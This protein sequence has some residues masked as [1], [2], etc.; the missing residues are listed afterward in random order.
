MSGCSLVAA[1]LP[2]L[3]GSATPTFSYDQA[4]HSFGLGDNF[5]IQMTYMPTFTPIISNPL[6]F[7]TRTCSYQTQGVPATY[8]GIFC[9][10]A[11][12]FDWVNM[13]RYTIDNY[14]FLNPF[15][16]TPRAFTAAFGDQPSPSTVATS[17]VQTT[18]TAT[19]TAF[20]PVRP[21]ATTTVSSASATST[22]TNIA[23]VTFS[24]TSAITQTFTLNF[25]TLLHPVTKLI[26]F[27]F[28]HSIA[29][30]ICFTYSYPIAELVL[31]RVFYSVAKLICRTSPEFIFYTLPHPSAQLSFCGHHHSGKHHYDYSIELLFHRVALARFFQLINFTVSYSI[32]LFSLRRYH[33]CPSPSPS[34]PGLSCPASDGATFTTPQGDFVVECFIDRTNFDI[35]VAPGNPAD[36]EQCIQ[37]CGSTS[38][39][40]AVS[41]LPN[42]PCYL[43]SGLGA[44]RSN[45]GV[46]GA[47]I[48]S[49][50]VS[51]SS[52]MVTSSAGASSQS[53]ATTT[54]V[55]TKVVTA[56][57]SSS[58]AASSGASVSCPGSNGS[59]VTAS[60]MQYL[61][62]CGADYMGGDIAGPMSPTYP[63]SYEGCLAD[64][65]TTS[66]CVA[67][68]Y[69][70]NGPC[71]LKSAANSAGSN[72][73][74]IGGRL[75]RIV[76]SSAAPASSTAPASS[77]AVASSPTAVSLSVAVSSSAVVSSSTAI[78]SSAAPSSSMV[79]SSRISSS[80]SPSF[81]S[82]A[83]SSA[84]VTSAAPAPGPSTVTVTTTVSNTAYQCACTPASVFTTSSSPTSSSAPAA[85]PTGATS[86]P[87]SNG[88]MVTTSCGAVYAV[89]CNSDRFGNDLENGLVYTDTYEQCLQACDNTTGC[90]NVSWVIGKPG[91]CYMK[92][93][94]GDVRTNSNIIG[95]R[96]LSGCS[97][98]KLH[99]KH[100]VK[101]AGF[102]GPDSTF[103]QAQVTATSTA[104]SRTTVT[105]TSTPISGTATQTVFTLA[106]ATIISTTSVPTTV[107]NT[108]SV[109]TCPTASPTL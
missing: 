9:Q 3:I 98:F 35:G 91:A 4:K 101:R 99:R 48:A 103:T 93:S 22:Q 47:R 41:Y 39:C 57:S 68:S 32:V 29:K 108:F 88:S 92:G 8:T 6:L 70:I 2:S 13:G 73:N 87:G 23:T 5:G 95:G 90:V 51:S 60:G 85:S 1:G 71:Y 43:K 75:V 72:S 58:P 80:I 102:Y 100:V 50:S 11:D 69:V 67:A 24:V 19:N 31:N 64:C 42:G 76:S 79:T 16:A 65:S 28:P 34:A 97:N 44:P 55:S 36:Y 14:A 62:E 27:A 18:S 89:E 38:G 86:C 15:A 81:S 56:S 49:V 52:S 94:I 63:S 7:Y 104:T 12:L 45:S 33:H 54:V 82:A 106:S 96:K 30:F 26:F 25:F 20:A 10:N 78:S 83:T 21:A 105:T 77:S 37:A 61:V 107:F 66:G 84:P 46:W 53:V 40:Q 59:T 109:T 17:F 74:I